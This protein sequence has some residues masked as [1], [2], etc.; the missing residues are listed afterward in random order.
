MSSLVCLRA[1]VWCATVSSFLFRPIAIVA[2]SNKHLRTHSYCGGTYLARVLVA[3]NII[4]VFL[5]SFI[6]VH[7]PVDF[8]FGFDALSYY[9]CILFILFSLFC[10]KFFF[11]A[12]AG[13]IFHFVLI[14]LGFFQCWMWI[15]VDQR[16]NA[17]P[18]QLVM[19]SSAF[20]FHLYFLFWIN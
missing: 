16:Q 1:T 9:F 13:T 8:K 2:T 6:V 4:N 11:I 12:F 10:W 18:L 5:F 14:F 19:L 15:S 3:S 17:R 7:I 20:V